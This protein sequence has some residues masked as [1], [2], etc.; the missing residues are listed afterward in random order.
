M[1]GE[2]NVNHQILATFAVTRVNI[3]SADAAQRRAQ[4]NHLRS[5]LETHIAAAPDYDLVKLRAS[6][7]TAKGTAIRRRRGEGSDADVAAYLRTTDPDI[8]ESKVLDWLLARCIEVYGKTKVADDF[9]I[10]QHAVGITLHGSKLKIDVAPVLF[11]GDEQDR[12]HLITRQGERVLTSVTQHLE[13]IRSRKQEAGRGYAELIRLLKAWIQEAKRLDPNLRCKS[14]LLEL[15]V[16]H[17]WDNG[18]HGAPLQVDDYP[19]AFEQVLAYIVTTGL[20]APVVFTDHYAA[21]AVSSSSEPIQVW[22]PVNPGNNVASSYTDTNRRH[23]VDLAA[24]A[25]DAVSWAAT[26]P[27]C[28]AANDAWRTLFGPSFLGA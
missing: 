27:T 22:D 10:S 8:D 5:R 20:Q 14:F 23:L 12:G 3:S 17:L 15:I 9:V 21:N 7:S 19:A 16:A 24:E 28:G 6:G 26:S 2:R 1:A 4:V 11:Q 25:L 13:F 18:W